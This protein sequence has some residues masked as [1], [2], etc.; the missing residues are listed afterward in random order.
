MAKSKFSEFT[1]AQVESVR[2]QA[3]S[4]WDHSTETMDGFFQ[5][6]NDYERIGRVLLPELLE[7]EYAK[8]DDRS[9]LAPADIYINLNSLRANIL[10]ILF[11]RKPYAIL[12][13]RGK[14]NLKSPQVQMAEA[15]LQNMLD[16][17]EAESEADL[18]IH[19]ALY[20]GLSAVFTQWT[21]EYQRV[22]QRDEQSKQVMVNKDGRTIFVLTPVAEYAETISIDIRRCRIDPAADTIKD[23]RIVGFHR[24]RSLSDLLIDNRNNATFYNF[25]EKALRESSF[26][27]DKYYEYVSGEKQANPDMGV[28]NA[29]FGDKTVEEWL[30]YGLFRIQQPDGSFTVEDLVVSIANR[31]KVIGL[32]RNDLPINGWELFDFPCVDKEHGRIYPMGVVEPAM[33]A[34]LEKV[35]KLNQSIDGTNRDTYD[36]YIGDQS[37]CQ[38]LPDV[39]EH[40]PEQLLKVDLMASGARSIHEVFGPLQRPQ[41]SHDP[42]AQAASLTDTVQTIMR[43]SDYIQGLDPGRKET[44]TAVTELVAGGANLLQLL[45]TN[46]LTSFF[47]PAW[48]KQLIL[49]NFFKGHEQSQ[50]TTADGQQFDI[51]PGDLESLWQIDIE[52]ATAMDR[53]AM[54]RRFVEMYPLLSTDPFFDQYEVRKTAVQILQLP[55]ADRIL[56]PNSLLQMN[57]DRENIALGLG[58]YVPV[59]PQDQHQLHIQGHAEYIDFINS[60]EGQ[61]GGLN[62]KAAVQHNQEHEDAILKQ[63]TSLGNSKELGGNATGNQVQPD[64]AAQTRGSTPGN[65][66][67]GLKKERRS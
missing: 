44:A 45:V 18:A 32:K 16:V 1:T 14:P 58:A 51:N 17:A 10:K 28:E 3:I 49:Q 65:Q 6:V 27:W 52:V 57:V 30:I 7:Q 33:D 43:L 59:H 62:D 66:S 50:I 29:D 21:T 67:T 35:V 64:A 19:Q 15:V 12:C 53:P 38:N 42:F 8:H 61:Q 47:R 36:T 20:A 60:P 48:Q 46:L 54:I 11:S 40:V 55:N 13:E 63:N 56:P 24:T 31:D 26:D 22:P 41:R 39:I 37:A 34:Y 23:R 5:D 4:F 25:D 9:A 2:T